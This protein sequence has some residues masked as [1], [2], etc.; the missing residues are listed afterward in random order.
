M[1]CCFCVSTLLPASVIWKDCYPCCLG[2]SSQVNNKCDD[3]PKPKTTEVLQKGVESVQVYSA[4]EERQEGRRWRVFRI[5]DQEHKVD[6]KAIEP[7]KRV[8][9]HGGY[10]GDGLNAIIVFAVCLHA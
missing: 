3:L 2:N 6:M 10:Y 9:N 4:S 8:I 7:Y 5:G 1:V